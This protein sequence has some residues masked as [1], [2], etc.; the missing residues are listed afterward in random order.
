MV[1]RETAQLPHELLEGEHIDVQV[2][3]EHHDTVD[4]LRDQCHH[5][6]HKEQDY[7]QDSQQD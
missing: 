4:D 6:D 7:G 5:Q 2:P 3:D 1:R